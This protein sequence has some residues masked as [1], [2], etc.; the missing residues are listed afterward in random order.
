M[1][2]SITKW[3]RDNQVQMSDPLKKTSGYTT[4]EIKDADLVISFK[5]VRHYTSPCNLEKFLKTW[6]APAAKSIFPYRKFSSIEECEATTEF[7]PIS[8][9]FN[10]LKQV[11]YFNLFV[12][13]K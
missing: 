1:I 13:Y 9:F 4:L 6:K 3:C 2:G 5:D 7:P 11:R 8:D 12:T 10:D